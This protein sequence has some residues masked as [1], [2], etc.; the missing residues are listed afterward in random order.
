MAFKPSAAK[1][2]RDE[3]EG[4]LNMNSMMDMMTI[5]LLFLLKSFSTQ[6][7]LITPSGDLQLPETIRNEKP[8]KVVTVAI[9]TR[10]ITVNDE[11]V[12]PIE[13]VL[14]EGNRIG[15]LSMR[16][17]ELAME[18]RELEA[19]GASP[20]EHEVLIQ[21]DQNLP[22]EHFFKVLYTCGDSEFY[23]M[24]ILSVSNATRNQ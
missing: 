11:I 1:R 19:N 23:N 12:A 5:I 16:L 3:S 13:A 24:R 6:G 15:P 9:S 10:A 21:G 17:K 4:A 14:E 22:Y 8:K 2:H 7:Q 20:F 18:A